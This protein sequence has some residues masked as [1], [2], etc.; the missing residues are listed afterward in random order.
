M[1]SKDGIIRAL[2]DLYVNISG[3]IVFGLFLYV[4]PSLVLVV[5]DSGDTLRGMCNIPFVSNPLKFAG[6][7]MLL[8][9]INLLVYFTKL[10]TLMKDG[11]S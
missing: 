1:G 2:K 6:G 7:L 9:G 4:L 3:L 8:Y 11:I 10:K 5:D